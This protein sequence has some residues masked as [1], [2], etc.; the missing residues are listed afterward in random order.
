M[1]CATVH[2]IRAKCLYS[3]FFLLHDKS[4]FLKKEIIC[5]SCCLFSAHS[6]L[7]SPVNGFYQ[8]LV[9]SLPNVI[10]HPLI[11]IISAFTCCFMNDEHKY[12]CSRLPIIDFSVVFS[13]PLDCFNDYCFSVF[14]LFSR[15]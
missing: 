15:K 4:K 5:A 11:I 12:I 9:V 2:K 7:F 6:T 3:R 10:L 14:P 1:T 8:L 13:S